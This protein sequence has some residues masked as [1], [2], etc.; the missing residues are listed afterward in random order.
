M[1][2]FLDGFQSS[3]RGAA[4]NEEDTRIF[5]E[6]GWIP[7]SHHHGDGDGGGSTD[8]VTAGAREK[9]TVPN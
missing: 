7:E 4:D 5:G 1:T 6:G 2:S 3:S 9:E 8:D